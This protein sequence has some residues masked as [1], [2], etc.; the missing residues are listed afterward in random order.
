M[1]Q[2]ILK[3]IKLYAIAVVVLFLISAVVTANVLLKRNKELKLENKRLISNN[4]Y[5]FGSNH[6]NLTLYLKE[7]ELTYKLRNEKDSIAKALKVKPKYIDKII[8]QTITEKDTVVREVPVYVLEKNKWAIS[9]TGKCFTWAGIV[10]LSDNFLSVKRTN[11]S[12]QNKTTSV[13]Y[14]KRTKQI[15]FIKYGKRTNFVQR[16]SECGE[17]F[18]EEFN[19]IK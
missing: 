3:N 16:T 7:K 14:R 15:F 1:I 17:S 13:Y 10:S 18:T 19:F 11:F 12:Y 9:D 4:F 2:N 6:K 8:Y 5:L